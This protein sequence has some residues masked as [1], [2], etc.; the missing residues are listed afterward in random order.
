MKHNVSNKCTYLYTRDFVT[1]K[2]SFVLL[3]LAVWRNFSA[4]ML[5]CYR[6]GKFL[7][8]AVCLADIDYSVGEKWE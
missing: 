2:N 4:C 7:D 8:A 3:I 1:C 5:F 6:L